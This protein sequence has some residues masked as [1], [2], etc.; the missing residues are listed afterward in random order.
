M[1]CDVAALGELLI[2][3]TQE[4]GKNGNVPPPSSGPVRQTTAPAKSKRPPGC[5]GRPQAVKKF[6]FDSLSKFSEPVRS[7]EN[8]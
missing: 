7:S 2:D 3:F 1:I 5:T 4:K 8:F 6:F